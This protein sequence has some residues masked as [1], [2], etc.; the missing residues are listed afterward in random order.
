MAL[1][2][3][4]NDARN[5]FPPGYFSFALPGGIIC[6]LTPLGYDS[7]MLAAFAPLAMYETCFFAFGTG[8]LSFRPIFKPCR[9]R[10]MGNEWAQVSG[11]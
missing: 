10:P 11:S 6:G 7:A 3:V 5:Q 8:L 2:V 1:E 4:R 9:I